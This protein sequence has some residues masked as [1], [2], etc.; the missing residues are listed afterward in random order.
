MNLS[1]AIF[2]VCFFTPLLITYCIYNAVNRTFPLWLSNILGVVGI[3]IFISFIFCMANGE[4]LDSKCTYSEYEIQ[5]LSF[6][7][8]KFNEEIYSLNERC[9]MVESPNKKYNNI[10]VVEKETYSFNW[11]GK[12]KTYSIKFHVYLSD[13]VYM[14]LKNRKLIYSSNN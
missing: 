3:I 12:V 11:I 7:T 8:I 14:I 6:N 1:F 13:D 5:E 2:I 9:V 4:H 10:V